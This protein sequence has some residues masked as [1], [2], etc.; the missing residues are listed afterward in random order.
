[1]FGATPKFLSPDGRLG[2]QLDSGAVRWVGHKE[3]EWM[4]FGS[5]AG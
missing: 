3:V 4:D 5:L 1:V 2:I